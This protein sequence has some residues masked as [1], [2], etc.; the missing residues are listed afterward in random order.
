[1]IGNYLELICMVFST[2]EGVQHPVIIV[3]LLGKAFYYLSQC[4][5]SKK[6]MQQANIGVENTNFQFKKASETKPFDIILIS[7]MSSQ[8]YF[9]VSLKGNM[10]RF[11]NRRETSGQQRYCETSFKV[12]MT[13]GYRAT[14]KRHIPFNQNIPRSPCYSFGRPQKNA[15][16]SHV[17][18]LKSKSLVIQVIQCSV[19]PVNTGNFCP[20]LQVSTVWGFL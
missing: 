9:Y 8:Q 13:Q 11:I 3:K 2:E 4:F 12:L 15:P 6:M 16:W 19:N 18:V 7:L 14:R 20:V 1:M 17:M 5:I 10:C